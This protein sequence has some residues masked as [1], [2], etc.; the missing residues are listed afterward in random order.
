MIIHS[1]NSNHEKEIL[2]E[3]IIRDWTLSHQNR[4][5]LANYRKK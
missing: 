3:E 4:Q 2:D 1:K 5:M